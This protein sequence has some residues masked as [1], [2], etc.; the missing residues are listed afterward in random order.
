LGFVTRR[1]IKKAEIVPSITLV[2]S[3]YNEAP[4][5]EATIRNKFEQHYPREKIEYIVVSDASDDGTDEIVQKLREKYDSLTFIR[6][7][8]RLG[9]TAALNKAV[10]EANGEIV[11]FSDANSL[12]KEDAIQKLVRNFA[13]PSVGYVTGKMVY[14]SASDSAVS[15]GC[16]SY[17]KYENKLRL[18]E[19]E[20][21]SIVGVDGGI[22]AVRKEL[23]EEM[24]PEDLP[25]FVLPLQVI[26]K[27][28]RVVYEPDALLR[29]DALKS[30]KSEFDMRVRVALRTYHGLLKKINLLN[31]FKFGGFSLS[32][33]SHKVLR[34]N[35]G[36]FQIL[37][38]CL[39]I[40]LSVHDAFYAVLLGIQ[41][42]L[43]LLAFLG[44]VSEK[45]GAS[46]S[47]LYFPYYFCLVNSAS[48][49]ALV[50]FLSGSRQST[51]SPRQG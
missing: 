21:G 48:V 16:S 7:D 34:Y 20:F 23:Y 5:I 51:W 10:S 6:Q 3:A 22:D 11:L 18:W 47:I 43:Y 19:T 31:F 39:N 1:V 49:V 29:E 4:Y 17:M 42:I 25:D 24:D 8:T 2:T 46:R 50:K 40:V 9:K 12:Y 13:D 44:L 28:Y 38:L 14:I 37:I 27:G 15:E 26:E 45:R 32:L 41:G 36:F 33:F 35:A 30:R